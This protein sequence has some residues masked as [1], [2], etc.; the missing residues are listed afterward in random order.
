MAGAM[1]MGARRAIAIVPPARITTNRERRRGRSRYPHV[2][3]EERERRPRGGIRGRKG[4]G[5]QEERD[6]WL[7]SRRMR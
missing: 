3:L 2:T 1:M 7:P 5:G 4:A 6:R